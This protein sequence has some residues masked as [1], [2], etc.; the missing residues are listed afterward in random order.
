MYFPVKQINELI[1]KKSRKFPFSRDVYL[2]LQT[3]QIMNRSQ[4]KVHA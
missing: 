2:L 1:L 3:V 4:P